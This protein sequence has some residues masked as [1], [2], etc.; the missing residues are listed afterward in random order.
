MFGRIDILVNNAAVFKQ[1]DFENIPEEELDDVI[2]IDLKGPF[3]LTQRVFTQM[4]KQKGGKVINI[5]SGAAKL[6]SSKASH[7]AACKAALISLTKSLAKLG[8]PHNINVNAVAPG[9]IETDMI[10]DILSEKRET[11]ES[12]IPL[13]RIGLTD[14]VASVVVFLASQDSDYITGQTICV[15]GG[16]CMI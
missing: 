6:G 4:K 8:G 12:F 14:E 7:Y 9:F 16:H 10:Q 2:D 1:T 5:C 3:L 13:K 15:D 11:I